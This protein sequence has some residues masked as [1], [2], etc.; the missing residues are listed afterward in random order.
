[1][2][3]FRHSYVIDIDE[4]IK[5]CRVLVNFHCEKQNYLSLPQ[6]EGLQYLTFIF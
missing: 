6:N 3:H 2:N 4:T 5:F 1:M